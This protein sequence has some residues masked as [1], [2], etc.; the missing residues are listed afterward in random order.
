M[1]F[2]VFLLAPLANFCVT[3]D[4]VSIKWYGHAFFTVTCGKTVIA[5]DPYNDKWG[6]KTREV[7]A[8]YCICSHAHEDHNASDLVVGTKEVLQGPE[9]FSTNWDDICVESILVDHD[10]NEGKKRG[11]NS[12]FVITYKKLKIAHFGDIGRVLTDKEKEFLKDVDVVM[13]PV[14]GKYVVTPETAKTVAD[15]LSAKVVI[16]MHYKTEEAKWLEFGADD[17]TKLFDKGDVK[18][19]KKNT[20]VLDKNKIPEKRQIWVLDYVR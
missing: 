19:V 9:E 20:A 1:K 17:F 4:E 10:E 3:Q 11:K 6:Y 16:P 13:I 5:I 12:I 2:F 15:S 18:I 8:D 14:G 7:K